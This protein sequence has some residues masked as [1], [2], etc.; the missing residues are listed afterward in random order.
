MTKIELV[1]E[2]LSDF[3][4]PDI[5]KNK[6]RSARTRAVQIPAAA[7][8]GNAEIMHTLLGIELKVAKSR[9]TC[10]DLA[11]AR[12]LLVFARLGCAEIAVPYDITKISPL[13]DEL[14]TAWQ[15]LL[16][17]LDVESNGQSAASKSRFKRLLLRKIRQ[18]IE[19]IGAGE[20][21]PEFKQ[22]TG[23]TKN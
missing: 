15:R 13:A 12:Y 8:V 7:R 10:P 1:R 17:I 4:I 9:L 5:Y 20:K 23:Q 6:I 14:E 16:L 3:W 21:M 19:S 18:E 22:S 11:T 2:K